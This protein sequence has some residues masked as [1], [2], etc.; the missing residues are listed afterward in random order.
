MPDPTDDPGAVALSIAGTLRRLDPGALA[1]LRRREDATATPAFWRLAARHDGL[2]RR[3]ETWGPI[4]RALAIL[5]PKGAPEDR[6][7][8]HDGA[9]K[10]GT[11]LC[12]GGD[13]D[14]HRGTAPRPMLSERRLAQLMAARGP[15]RAVLL[16]RAIRALGA[17]KPADAKIDVADL[18][19]TFL[20]PDPARLAR[21]Y[22]V[23]LDRAEAQKDTT[24]A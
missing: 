5:T 16:I 20:N 15:Q 21:P 10:L 18:A 2:V 17:K 12:D 13:P 19:W 6:P 4:V 23:R 7:E 14:W 8:L 9:R 1:T 24:D 11:C 22:Y 3:P